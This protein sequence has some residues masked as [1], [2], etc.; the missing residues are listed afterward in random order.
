MDIAALT[1]KNLNKEFSLSPTHLLRES[2][3]HCVEVGRAGGE[4]V[5]VGGHLNVAGREHDVREE[6]RPPHR[7]Q[8][9]ER[10]RRM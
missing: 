6:A 8:R 2:R 5:L 10:V 9:F 4:H 3:E 7:V 1:S